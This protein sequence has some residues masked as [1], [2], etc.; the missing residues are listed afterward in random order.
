MSAAAPPFS[1]HAGAAARGQVRARRLA[2]GAVLS[3]LALA[4]LA[5]ALLAVGHGAY[6]IAPG[7]VLR[8]LAEQASGLA[9]GADPQQA[10]VLTTI[11]LPRVLLAVLTGAGLAVAGALTQGLFRNP[12]ADPALIGVSAGAALAAA[13]V[14][15]LGAF[16]LPRGW[17]D[18]VA[19]M[20]T[21]PLAAFAGGLTVTWLVYRIGRAQGVL[22]LPMTLL[23]GIAIN[24]MAMAGIGLLVYMASDE[25]LR[26]L[27]FWN[28]GSLAAA[29]WS[30]L[31]AV[32][33][34]AL[35]AM[36]AAWRLA[37][38]LNA[39][40]LG[41]ARAAHLGVDVT[42]AKRLTIV[43]AA[44]A[45]GSLVA[46]T[47]MIGFVGLVAPHLVRL[48]C[49]PDH[50]IVL[51]GA[52]LLGAV[53]VLIADMVARTVVAPA[54]LPIGILTAGFGAPFFLLLLLR[55][56]AAGSL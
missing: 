55:R 56:R 21:L 33:V 52:A 2:P 43:I 26:T 47:G 41:E 10:A 37:A 4:L 36:I 39:L 6:P 5:L 14:I 34:P 50:R 45:T 19:A 1:A 51:P 27:A 23:A 24:A 13:G 11:R 49:G 16:W 54:E 40:A 7:Q 35:V 22:S 17:R 25:Q 32:V 15:V 3:V 42:R 28:L 44:L 29:T 46:V 38:P 20:M 18:G 31:A 53:L 8:I 9:W 12:L 48:M 30:V